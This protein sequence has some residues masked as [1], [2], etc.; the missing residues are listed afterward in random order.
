M[1]QTRVD[2]R[3]LLEDLADAYPGSL[4]ESILVEIVA[5]ALDSGAALVRFHTDH[6]T[7][8][9][10]VVDDGRGMSRRELS[11]YH[12]LATT[13]KQRGKGI[14]FAGVGI[15]LGLLACDEVTTETRSARS[16][17][18]TSWHL[19]SKHKAPWR[20]IEPDPSRLG[21]ET[22]GTAVTLRPA[23]VLSPLLDGGFIEHVLTE[24]YRP[25]FETAFDQLLE[26]FYP[27]GIRFEVNGRPLSRLREA[28]ERALL[29]I[30]LKGKRKPS[31]V[32]YLVRSTLPLPEPER[33]VGVSTLGKVIRRGWD[34]LGIVP[35]DAERIGG[36]IEVP[37]LAECLTLSKADFIRSGPRGATFLTY[38]KALQE[39]VS[40]QLETWGQA[41]SQEPK[42]RRRTRPLERDLENV[43]VD[44][45]KTYP[46]LAA[47]VEKRRGG[48]RRIPLVTPDD[49]GTGGLSETLTG[50]GPESVE[51]KEED[52]AVSAGAESPG[53]TGTGLEEPEPPVPDEPQESTI[54][55]A[56]ARGSGRKHRR[57]GR[58]GLHIQFETRPDDPNLGRL[59]EST[60]LVN[61]AH[62]AYRRASAGRSEAYHLALTVAMV[63]APLAVEAD[64]VHAFITEFLAR[65]GEASK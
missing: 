24:H 55:A 9:L 8:T 57:P 15:K 59:V 3:H 63:L 29:S 35:L 5:N 34:W 11:R 46:L 28:G 18:A 42:R 14:G 49:S 40:A 32:G 13:S 41:G 27:G 43:L 44:L 17:A 36:L 21:S 4:E 51:D 33:G 2:L 12:D 10:V 47:L 48:Q 38:R 65:W 50:P 54:P 45:A 20:W 37:P 30:R 62:P 64:Q 19:A 60:V 7:R 56:A 6:A 39:V 31:A 22:T 16:H 52:R 25:L 26:G 58:F 61:D 53:V 1:G 23:N